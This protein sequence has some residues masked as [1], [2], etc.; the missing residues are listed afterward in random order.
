MKRKLRTNK[1]FGK[2]ATK[3][4]TKK[5]YKKKNSKGLRKTTKKRMHRRRG[6]RK[7]RGGV[8][9]KDDEP[10]FAADEDAIL[11][12]QDDGEEEEVH[13]LDLGEGEN[14]NLD[15]DAEMS[16]FDDNGSLHLSD[17]EGDT[18]ESGETTRDTGLSVSNPDLS[19]SSFSMDEPQGEEEPSQMGG[20]R[21][22]G[23]KRVGKKTQ[24]R[25]RGKKGGE[26][27]GDYNPNDRS[28]DL[29]H[30]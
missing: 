14:L 21:R 6:S 26:L 1:K 20:K 13:N 2:R 11:P 15:D 22:K 3:R 29:D 28:P 16:G 18:R 10:F 24:K 12:L 25:R 27:P 23:I 8:D 7:M 30:D 5:N 4:A 9:P 17:L 19:I